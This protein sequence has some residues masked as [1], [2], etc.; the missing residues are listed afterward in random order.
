MAPRPLV[1]FVAVL[2]VVEGAVMAWQGVSWPV[3]YAPLAV[4]VIGLLFPSITG[5]WRTAIIAIACLYAAVFVF[6]GSIWALFGS[7]GGIMGSTCSNA[8]FLGGVA[9][10]ALAAAVNVVAAV[11]IVKS[12]HR[13]MKVDQA[14]GDP[15]IE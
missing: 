2:M 14:G 5:F 3:P 15:A 11:L 10:Y 13:T 8:E 12:G 9:A 7:C 1:I 4:V 6:P